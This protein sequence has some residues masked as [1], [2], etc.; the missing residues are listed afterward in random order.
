MGLVQKT[1]TDKGNEM[2]NKTVILVEKMKTLQKSMIKLSEALKEDY[3]DKSAEIKGASQIMD[4][5]IT[6]IKNEK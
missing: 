4:S 1:T 3:P 5:W 2:T 6:G